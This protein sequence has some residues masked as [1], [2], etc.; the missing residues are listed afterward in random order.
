MSPRN[1]HAKFTPGSDVEFWFHFSKTEKE[2]P[3]EKRRRE[4]K[5]EKKNKKNRKKNFN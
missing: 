5:E 2:F 3:S 1:Y 4:L